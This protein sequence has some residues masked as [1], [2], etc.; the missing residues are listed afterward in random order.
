MSRTFSSVCLWK[1]SRLQISSGYLWK[2]LKLAVENNNQYVFQVIY[3][4]WVQQQ[5]KIAQMIAYRS[6]P[7]IP[8]TNYTWSLCIGVSCTCYLS[9]SYFRLS[10]YKALL[11]LSLAWPSLFLPVSMMS[12]SQPTVERNLNQVLIRSH[13]KLLFW[14]LYL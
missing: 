6:E 9:C 5:L 1:K 13:S 8:S 3:T 10:I 12:L 7:N 2:I 14:Y 11:V 4:L